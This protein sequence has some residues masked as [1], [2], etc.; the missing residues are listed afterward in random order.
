MSSS[1]DDQTRSV[2]DINDAL[3]AC[4]MHDRVAAL[5]CAIIRDEP[6][7]APCSVRLGLVGEAASSARII[8][9]LQA[10]FELH[11]PDVI[12][13]VRNTSPSVYLR[14]VALVCRPAIDLLR[15]AD[16]GDF[17]QMET[18]E[19]V[20]AALTEQLGPERTELIAKAL[21]VSDTFCVGECGIDFS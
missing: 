15:D 7:C 1:T 4:P 8:S 19:E 16:P 20:L 5:A 13:K 21:G 10:D 18:R 2:R 11:G 17:S 14:T 6:A 3:L 12:E 9:A